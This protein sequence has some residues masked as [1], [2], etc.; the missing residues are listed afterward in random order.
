ML[1][2]DRSKILVS[3]IIPI[4]N[5]EQYIAQ[6]IE[7]VIAQT[8]EKFELIL[9]NDGSTDKSGVIADVY[10]KKDSRIYVVHTI[11]GGVSSARNK[12]LDLAAGD[13]VAFI[14]GDD[15]VMPDYL[16]YSNSTYKQST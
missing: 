7:S 6:N 16:D 15:Y 14:D 10:S 13:Y 5:V 3:V 1:K 9:I 4:Y 11:N 8:H 2:S 12:G